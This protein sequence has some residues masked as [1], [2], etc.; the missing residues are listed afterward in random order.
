[1]NTS[2]VVLL[3]ANVNNEIQAESLYAN[4]A[5]DLKKLLH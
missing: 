4:Y 1:M 2:P 5:S 3:A